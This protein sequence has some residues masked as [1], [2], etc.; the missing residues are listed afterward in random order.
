MA[1]QNFITEPKP[2]SRVERQRFYNRAAWKRIRRRVL[3]DHPLCQECLKWGRMAP[4]SVC[5][6]VSPL[7][8]DW[9]G[10]IKG[11]FQGLCRSC[12]TDK[13][14]EDNSKK[15]RAAALEVRAWQ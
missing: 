12:H 1:A 4:S 6:H 11:P 3:K 15:R 7:W 10:F 5:D 8:N 14:V 13:M 9:K 2:L